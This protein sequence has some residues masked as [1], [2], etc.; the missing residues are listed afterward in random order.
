MA[1]NVSGSAD[2]TSD[3]NVTPMVDVMLVLLIIFMVVT[4]LLQAGVTVTLPRGKNPDEDAAITK[5]TA[6]VVAIPWAGAYYVGRDQVTRERLIQTIENRMKTLK[7]S[8]QIV[9]IKGGVN[10]QYGE[11]V[12]VINFI[13]EAGYDRI[14]LVA[15]KLKTGE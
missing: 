12:D 2:L 14:G 9:Y 5:D 3:I 8:D 7:A 6:V 15:E 4:P 10:V 13:R 1:M 11:V